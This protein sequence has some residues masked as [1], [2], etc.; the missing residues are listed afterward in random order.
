MTITRILLITVIVFFLYTNNSF[1]QKL[2]EK[3]TINYTEMNISCIKLFQNSK[4]GEVYLF[5]F[6]TRQGKNCRLM[7]YNSKFQIVF[8][9][10]NIPNEIYGTDVFA[11]REYFYFKGNKQIYKINTSVFTLDSIKTNRIYKNLIVHTIK[12]S[13]ILVADHLNGFD[14]FSL[15]GL[16]LNEEINVGGIANISIPRVYNDVIYFNTKKNLLTAYDFKKHKII[17]NFDGGESKVKFMGIKV[18]SMPNTIKRYKIYSN[19]YLLVNSFGGDLFKLD[20]ESGISFFSK[21]KFRGDDNNAGLLRSLTFVDINK[22]GR[23]EIIAPSVDHN[24]YCISEKDFSVLW[25]YNTDDENQ[26]PVSLYD[27]NNDQIPDVLS[28]ND[29]LKLSIINGSDGRLL[30]EVKLQTESSFGQSEII[31]SDFNNNNLLDLFVIGRDKNE[32]TQLKF[33]EFSNVYAKERIVWE[34]EE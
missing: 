26:I 33:L 9:K 20:V 11:N 16:K 2:I 5:V 12:D 29:K 22:D 23:N 18:G 14:L 24:I 6:L 8:K 25:S 15:P 31:L 30:N 19:K 28:V 21:K 10:E 1:P 3:Y 13:E 27:V 7:V 4:N 32:S 17:W 34:P